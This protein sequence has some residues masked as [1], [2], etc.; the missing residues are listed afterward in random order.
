MTNGPLLTFSVAGRGIGEEVRLERP[1][2]VFIEGSVRF[3]PERDE[4]RLLEV[5]QNGEVIKTIQQRKFTAET[6]FRF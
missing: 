1:G 4:V 3:D 2:S 5:V 6:R